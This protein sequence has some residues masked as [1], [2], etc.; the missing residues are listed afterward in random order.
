LLFRVGQYEAQ[1]HLGRG[2]FADVYLA[3]DSA[4]RAVALKLILPEPLAEPNS[5]ERLRREVATMQRVRSPRVAGI[6]D[7]T[8]GLPT[9]DLTSADRIGRTKAAGWA[10]QRG[11]PRARL[12]TRAQARRARSTRAQARRARSATRAKAWRARGRPAGGAA[13]VRGRGPM[14]RLRGDLPCHGCR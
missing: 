9:R 13:D 8:S 14:R 7:C 4:K 10:A 12:A 5:R 2:G 3:F 6:I 1:Y 11:S